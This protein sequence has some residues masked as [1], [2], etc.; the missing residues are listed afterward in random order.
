M[1]ILITG[2]LPPAV[3][4]RLEKEH[5][6]RMHAEDRPMTADAL[7]AAVKGRDGLLCMITDR[8]DAELMDGAGNLRMIA[9]MGVG[10]DNI[11]LK[12]ASA[13]GITVSNTPGVLTD[14]TADLTLGLIL[15]AARRVVEG[16][17][18]TR[19]G[20]FRFWAP[21]YF[22]GREVTGKT[23]GIV[24]LGRIG[25]AVVQRAAGFQMRIIYYGRH[26]LEP[27]EEKA[28]GVNFKNLDTLLEEADYVSLHVPLTSET[29]HMVG[30]RELQSMKP[31]ACLIN[32]SR[33][34]VVDERALVEA[35]R[36][37]VIAGAALDVYEREPA[38]TAGLKDLNNVVL[39]PHMGS[40]TIETR[41][42]MAVL[43]AENL[44]AGLRGER[45]PNSLNWEDIRQ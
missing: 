42:K 35:L 8:I 33:G 43:A 21:F 19:E 38:L 28:L 7:K 17:R 2:N 4:G 14:A 6:I 29:R 25:R 10:Y 11:D 26:R 44:M 40:A 37:Q 15:A 3:L 39:L 23:L 1:R 22:L 41:T 45:P 34:A 31:T 27:Y 16:D 20:K 24:G 13:R 32:T 30:M 12:A 36:K 9:N 5:D 18:Y